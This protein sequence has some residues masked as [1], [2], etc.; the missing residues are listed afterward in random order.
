V[1]DIVVDQKDRLW[2]LDTGGIGF[3]SITYGGLGLVGIDF[4]TNKI[5]K[6]ITFTEGIALKNTC[7]NDI[8]FDLRKG[9]EWFAFIADSEATA[10]LKLIWPRGKAGEDSTITQKKISSWRRRATSR[11]QYSKHK[12]ISSGRGC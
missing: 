5:F 7:F 6:K 4:S 10:L 8:R 3:G 2:V 11:I 9:F 12:A 1:E